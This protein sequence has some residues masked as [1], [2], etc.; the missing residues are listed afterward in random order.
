MDSLI[1]YIWFSTT[2]AKCN[3]E[4]AMFDQQFLNK[5]EYEKLLFDVS[6]C[7][8]CNSSLLLFLGSFCYT[9]IVYFRAAT[10]AFFK[11]IYLYFS[12][13]FQWH[14][15][16][17]KC[18]ILHSLPHMKFDISISSKQTLYLLSSYFVEIF[19]LTDLVAN[20]PTSV[21]LCNSW[22]NQQ[23]ISSA[24]MCMRIQTSCFLLW[25]NTWVYMSC[26]GPI[27]YKILASLLKESMQIIWKLCPKHL[28][29]AVDFLPEL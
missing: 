5:R 17:V 27:L 3:D 6:I 9:F 16:L 25:T 18:V 4:H 23:L 22:C 14:K 26:I 2:T 19:E 28:C 20:Q 8:K 1:F 12:L 21:H 13:T 24:V 7:L 10:S 11:F 15:Y 29:C